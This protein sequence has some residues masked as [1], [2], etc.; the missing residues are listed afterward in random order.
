[1][2]NNR[3]AKLNEVLWVTAQKAMDILGGCF[4]N[5]IQCL[6]GVKGIMGRY[7]DIIHFCEYI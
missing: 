6:M 1:M 2:A 4:S 3:L 7:D 5:N